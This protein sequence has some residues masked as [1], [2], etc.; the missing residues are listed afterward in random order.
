MT[1]KEAMEFIRDFVK[2]RG[3][4]SDEISLQVP[5]LYPA[6]KINENYEVGE[7]VLY[8]DILY[9]VL[10]PHTSQETWTPIDAPSLFARV[11]IVDENVIPEWIQ[12]DST[13]AYMIGDKVMFDGEVYESTIDNNIWSPVDYPAGWQKVQQ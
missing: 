8:E 13:N 5:N 11:L 1:R 7:R 3:L 9:K 2:L 6:W 4:V 10:Q 12:P